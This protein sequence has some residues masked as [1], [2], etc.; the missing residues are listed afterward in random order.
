MRETNVW[1]AIVF[2]VSLIVAS[3]LIGGI[4]E[5][6]SARENAAFIWRINRFAGSMAVCSTPRPLRRFSSKATAESKANDILP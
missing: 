1:A 2:A 6:R 5:S 3:V 4:Y